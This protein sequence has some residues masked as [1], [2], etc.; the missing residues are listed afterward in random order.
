[1]IAN[2]VFSLGEESSN[3]SVKIQDNNAIEQDKTIHVNCSTSDKTIDLLPSCTNV[4][5]YIKDDDCEYTNL[6]EIDQGFPSKNDDT[7]I[8]LFKHKFPKRNK[9]KKHH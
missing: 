5:I 1:M 7:S 3:F 6:A 8:L 2:V 4:L 9:K